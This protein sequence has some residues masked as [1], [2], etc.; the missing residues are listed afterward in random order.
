MYRRATVLMLL[1]VTLIIQVVSADPAILSKQSVSQGSVV[2]LVHNQI[3]A[4]IAHQ[5]SPL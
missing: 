2:H 4:S 3:I 5:D 1:I